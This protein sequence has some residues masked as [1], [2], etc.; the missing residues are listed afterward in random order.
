MGIFRWLRLCTWCHL[1]HCVG[2]HGVVVHPT[3]ALVTGWGRGTQLADVRRQIA[4]VAGGT[5]PQG[6]GPDY[7]KHLQ[8]AQEVYLQDAA[9]ATRT[10]AWLK[11]CSPLTPFPHAPSKGTRDPPLLLCC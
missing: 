10:G 7:Q 5:L 9:T 2:A 6:R 11:A 1:G 4:A 3:R 8:E